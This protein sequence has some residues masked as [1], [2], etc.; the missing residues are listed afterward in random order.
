MKK[1]VKGKP[2]GRTCIAHWKRCGSDPQ[3]AGG[4]YVNE[5]LFKKDSKQQE[6]QERAK[7]PGWKNILKGLGLA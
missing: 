7:N 6:A 5:D 3:L 2:C 1:C 4:G